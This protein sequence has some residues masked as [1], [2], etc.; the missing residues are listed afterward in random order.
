MA[1][2]ATH[3]RL[4]CLIFGVIALLLY[5]PPPSLGFN[6]SLGGVG[7]L[8]DVL[9]QSPSS[10]CVHCCHGHSTHTQTHTPLQFLSSAFP[11]LSFSHNFLTLLSFLPPS[12]PPPP[13][14]LPLLFIKPPPCPFCIL[15][16]AHLSKLHS[17]HRRRWEQ[18]QVRLDRYR[19]PVWAKESVALFTCVCVYLYLDVRVLTCKCVIGVFSLLP[20]ALLSGHTALRSFS[21]KTKMLH[22]QR[23]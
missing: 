10:V 13:Y 14:L 12:S 17:K 6:P 3:T 4:F 11:F 21:I 18:R 16:S 23:H 7:V 5:H 19:E 1:D 2:P 8:S 15:L 22:R 20:G 9:L